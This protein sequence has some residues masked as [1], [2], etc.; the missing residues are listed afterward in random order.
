MSLR[1]Y[2]IRV[3]FLNGK[4]ISHVFYRKGYIL[5]NPYSPPYGVFGATKIQKIFNKRTF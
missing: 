4:G 5:L 3:L 1:Q 2:K